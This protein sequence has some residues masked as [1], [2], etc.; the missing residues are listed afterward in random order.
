M[1]INDILFYVNNFLSDKI[2]IVPSTE[3]IWLFVIQAIFFGFFLFVPYYFI[4]GKKN[5]DE[6]SYEEDKKYEV[7]KKFI[8]K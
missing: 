1:N 3:G 2:N 8:S 7:F 5:F 6:S 4:V